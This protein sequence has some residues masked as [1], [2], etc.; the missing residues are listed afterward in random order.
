M[1]GKLWWGRFFKAFSKS[2]GASFPAQPAA[3]AYSVSLI[4][5]FGD[6][7]SFEGSGCSGVFSLLCHT[8]AALKCGAGIDDQDRCLDIAV[9]TTCGEDFNAAFAFDISEHSPVN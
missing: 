1:P 4:Y 6:Q 8:A 3:L 9:D 5:T 7:T 2:R